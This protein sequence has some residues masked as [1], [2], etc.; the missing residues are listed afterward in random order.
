MCDDTHSGA[1]PVE[2]KLARAWPLTQTVICRG[3]APARRETSRGGARGPDLALWGCVRRLL[4]FLV[5]YEP[6]ARSKTSADF[7]S[8]CGG[9]AAS[10]VLRGHQ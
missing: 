7:V 10:R 5:S 1:A 9:C 2:K 3:M 6:L 8:L 4:V